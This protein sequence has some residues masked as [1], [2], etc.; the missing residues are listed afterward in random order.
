MS[1]L[2]RFKSAKAMRIADASDNFVAPHAGASVLGSED[3]SP[4][5]S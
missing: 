4:A 2:R 5:N 1:I 3:A